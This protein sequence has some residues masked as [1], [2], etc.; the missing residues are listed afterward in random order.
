M[1]GERR[2]RDE[3]RRGDGRVRERVA[4]RGHARLTCM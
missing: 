2:R 1:G 4:A 3:H